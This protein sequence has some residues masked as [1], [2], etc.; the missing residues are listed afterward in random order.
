MTTKC[1]L[2]GKPAHHIHHRD[3]NHKNND[4]KNWQHLCTKC[5]SKLHGIEFKNSELRKR[6]IYYSRIQRVKVAIGNSLSGFERVE[7]E[8]PEELLELQKNLIKMEK[9]KE[10]EIKSF[11]KENPMAIHKWLVSIKGISDILASR[12]IALIDID[13][14]PMVSSL[15]SYAGYKPTDRKAKGKKANWNQELKMVCYQ[16][17]DSFVKHRT[18]KYRAIYDAEKEK[19]IPI[20]KLLDKKGWKGHADMR[21]RRKAVKEFLKDLFVEWKKPLAILSSN[22]RLAIPSTV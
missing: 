4:P 10:K 1:E 18:P 19:Q 15:W 13:K 7:L 17:S 20:C 14:T 21:A 16:V 12:L 5:H 3:E 8:I 6:V 22:N 9:D 2:C 11:F